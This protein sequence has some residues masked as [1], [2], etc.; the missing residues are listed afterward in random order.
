MHVR[1][2]WML[3]GWTAVALAMAGAVLPLLPTTPFLLLAAFA[4]ARSSP[5][6]HAWL[7]DHPTFGKLI[8]NWQQHRSI[9]RRTKALAVGVMALTFLL[10]LALGVA[11]SVLMIQGVVLSLAAFFILT[12]PSVP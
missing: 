7:L 5:R 12:R 9:D 10:S 3:L 4:F 1:Y 11:S 2:L 8:H 6:L